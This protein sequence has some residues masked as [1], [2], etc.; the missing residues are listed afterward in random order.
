MR[1]HTPGVDAIGRTLPSFQAFVQTRASLTRWGKRRPVDGSGY[2]PLEQAPDLSAGVGKEFASLHGRPK[3]A[4]YRQS[5]ACCALENHGQDFQTLDS[6]LSDRY[7]EGE[8]VLLK[9]LGWGLAHGRVRGNFSPGAQ[10]L[11][12]AGR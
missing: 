10:E 6:A 2:R 11:D 5:W 9:S 1:R 8:C 4:R 12:R 3:L 7:L